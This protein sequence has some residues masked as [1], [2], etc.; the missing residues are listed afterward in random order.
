MFVG[1]D[2]YSTCQANREAEDVFLDSQLEFRD[3][4]QIKTVGGAISSPVSNSPRNLPSQA[5]GGEI[6]VAGNNPHLGGMARLTPALSAVAWGASVLD[7]IAPRLTTAIM[8]Q[9]FTRPRRKPGRDYRRMLPPG[10]Q[11]LTLNHGRLNL[12]GW[13]WGDSGPAVLLVHGWEDHS[14]SML[15]F[16]QP[17]LN[18]G[19]RVLV[20]DAPGHG[21]SPQASTHLVDTSFT[22]ESMVC[23]FGPFES[24]V[25]HSYGAAA[26]CLMLERS[27]GLTPDRLSLISPMQDLNQHLRVFADIALLSPDR[28]E[29]LRERVSRL[30]GQSTTEICALKAVRQLEVPAL[31]VHDRHDPV[32]PHMAGQNLARQLPGARFVS[33][34]RL[35]H[36]R[37]LRCPNVVREVLRHHR[38]LT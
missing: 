33:T 24:I 14:G 26:T 32:I 8:L 6:S 7:T 20:L 34:S 19:Y 38:K 35:G 11:R 30:I 5:R 27:P 21:L 17:L 25:A 22:L 9:H 15:S 29:R 4:A 28:A 23:A 31:V 13:A 1:L 3:P 16:V 12:T 18:L 2:T 36:R 10:Y 37:V